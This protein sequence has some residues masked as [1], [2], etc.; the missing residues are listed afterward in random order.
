[1]QDETPEEEE[2]EE[3]KRLLN[4]SKCHNRTPGSAGR[5][6]NRVMWSLEQYIVDST[7]VN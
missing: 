6:Q 5:P 3:G 7:I 1:M 4:P 2:E